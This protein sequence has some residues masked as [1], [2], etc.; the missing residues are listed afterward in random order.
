MQN[1]VS[2]ERGSSPS[3]CDTWAGDS[4]I[5]NERCDTQSRILGTR[6]VIHSNIYRGDGNAG[7]CHDLKRNINV[8]VNLLFTD[9]TV[10]CLVYLV[11]VI[12]RRLHSEELHDLYSSPSIIRMIRSRRMGWTGNVER[13][14]RTGMNI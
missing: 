10:V 7:L 3:P 14:G 1:K 2:G 11:D 5:R 6:R 12:A 13:M 8:N 4:N 9:R